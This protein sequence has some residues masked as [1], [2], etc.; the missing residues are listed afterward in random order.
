MRIG[1]ALPDLHHALTCYAQAGRVRRHQ[2][3]LRA[4]GARRSAAAAQVPVCHTV[5]GPLTGEPGDVYS[6]IGQVSPSR[7]PDLDLRFA[8]RRRCPTC[9]WL[10]TCH[11]AIAID[12]Y[13]CD[14]GNDGYL[15]FLGRMSPDKGAHHA[16]RLAREVGMPLM[17]AGKM[18]DVAEREHFDAE[19]RPYLND[20]IRV[21]GRGQPRR[22]GAAAAAGDG[23]RVPDPVAGAVRAGDGGVDGLRHAGDR[24]PLRR[25][26]GGDRAGPKRRHRGR[27]STSWRRRSSRRS[28][29]TPAS[30]GPAPTERF[31]PERMIRDYE[32]AYQR[33]LAW[34]R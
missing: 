10:A 23:D 17:L 1:L 20:E 21:R 26:A 5:H 19:V 4:A 31:S 3:P 13:P 11:N 9:N 28:R 14:A 32:D 15:L 27:A 33:L 25:R 30:A 6:L 29:S 22:E 24:H 2:R 18:H 16:V 12:H 34:S 7:R 8:A